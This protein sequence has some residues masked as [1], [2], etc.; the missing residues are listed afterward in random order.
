MRRP[1]AFLC[2][3]YAGGILAAQSIRPSFVF[4][5][6][7]AWVLWVLPVGWARVRPLCL[8]MLLFAVGMAN[9]RSHTDI[10]SNNDLRNIL[11]VE[12]HLAQVR[13]TFL[14]SP[15]VRESEESDQKSEAHSQ[16]RLKVNA[17][18]VDREPWKPAV[19]TVVL[20]TKGSLTNFFAGQLI[21]CEGVISLPPLPLAE[22]LFNYRL[23]LSQ[24]EI[25]Y[26]FKCSSAGDLRL[27]SGSRDAPFPDR[28][29]KWSSAQ[30]GRGINEDLNVQLERALTLGVKSI[31]T[32]DVSEP[33]IRAATYHI[34]AV[35]GLR[36]TI[37]FGIFFAVFRVFRI[38]RAHC[39]FLLLPIIWFY[40]HLTGW[41]ASAV[42][43]AV[44]LSIVMVVNVTHAV[45]LGCI[46]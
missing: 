14:E 43:A 33:F 32:G 2:L 19:G 37:L 7:G 11:G 46:Y 45:I 31:L 10:F 9:L 24:Q 21:E 41:P 34:F 22:G 28:F 30:L 18:Q 42:R 6:M 27:I 3:F 25:Y 4:L 5:V 8:P 16:V 44:M 20:S 12:S 38:S 39:G 36:M 29:A 13:G 15:V 26:L 35:D 23:F 17:I 1:A 40:V